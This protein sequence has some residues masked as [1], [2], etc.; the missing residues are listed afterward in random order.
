M[1]TA[2]KDKPVIVLKDKQGKNVEMQVGVELY[3]SAGDHK[4]DLRTEVRYAASQQGVNWDPE[5][6]D[7]IDQMYTASGLFDSKF[8]GNSPTLKE[9]SKQE[10]A[11]GFRAPDGPGQSVGARVLFPQLILET[12]KA[13][14]L[15]DD[16]NDLVSALNKSVAVTTNLNGARAD[17]PIIDARAPEGSDSGRMTQMAEPDTMVTITTSEKSYRI[18]TMSIGLTISDEAMEATTVDLVRIVMEAQARGER[19]RRAQAQLKALVLGDADYGMA[20]L[21]Q[22]T[23]KDFDNTLAVNEVSKKAYLKWLLAN[24]GNVNIGRI[25][26]SIDDLLTLDEAL[27]PGT[28]GVDASKVI[29]P[30][31]GWVSGKNAPEF[32]VVDPT[33]FGAGVFVGLDPRYAIQRFVN[34]TATYDAIEKY[35]MRKATSFRVDHGEMVTRLYDEA[36]SVMNLTNP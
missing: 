35:V 23:A 30:F 29:A 3:K 18:P 8:G 33:T 31:Q 2:T 6:G 36:W 22:V 27:L 11:N 32:A 13:G 21:P 4:R 28:T 10:L 17:Q 15:D 34:V 25:F 9:L 20:A 16:G 5:K 19:R 14:A 1:V 26:T 12:L 7:L 24:G